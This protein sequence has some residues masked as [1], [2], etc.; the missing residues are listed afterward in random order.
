MSLKMIIKRMRESV[1]IIRFMIV[2]T[3][4]ACIVALAVW[5]LMDLFH[6]NYIVS[7]LVGYSAALINNFFWS[8]YW[9]FTSRGGGILK[10][11]I[12][13]L[14]AFGCAYLT[15]FIFL[16]LMVECFHQNEYLSQFLGLFFYGLVNFLM[17]KYITFPNQMQ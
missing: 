1:R 8:K 3:S 4:N 11:I 16:V 9:V 7:N 2:G 10:E 13:F 5:I 17:N 6:V 12:L 15:Q 14:I